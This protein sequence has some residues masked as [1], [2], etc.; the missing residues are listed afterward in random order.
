V[1]SAGNNK[2][3]IL[4]IPSDL[5]PLLHTS[6]LGDTLFIRIQTPPY[7]SQEQKEYIETHHGYPAVQS[8]EW[9]LALS[10]Q[11]DYVASHLPRQKVIFSGLSRDSL[12]FCVDRGVVE[13]SQFRAL[14]ADGRELRFKSG[15]V[16]HLHTNLDGN[17]RWILDEKQFHLDTEHLSGSGWHQWSLLKGECRRLLWQP[18][19]KEATLQV[20]LHEG[21]ILEQR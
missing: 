10:A 19:T 20:T 5:Q 2:E 15:S 13:E 14:K 17:I 3:S 8:D 18:L 6:V 4:T 1:V 9:I 16:Q 21:A 7:R 11:T 12:A